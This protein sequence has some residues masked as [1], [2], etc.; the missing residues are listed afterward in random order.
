M[1]FMTYLR[2]SFLCLALMGLIACGGTKI[3]SGQ[4]PMVRLIELSHDQQTIELQLSMRN[5]N[6][7]RLDIQNIKVKLANDKVELVTYS[8]PANTN[9]VANGTEVWK[10]QI[11]ASDASSELLNTLQS[12]ETM[13]LPYTLE[14]VITSVDDGQLHFQHDGHLYPIPGRPGHFR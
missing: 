14:G 1:A 13:S 9:I 12:G 11:K 3:I 4:A 5:L 10:V 7:V 8:G 2:W 6:G